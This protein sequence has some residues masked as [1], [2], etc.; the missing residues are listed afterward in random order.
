M[1]HM[2]SLREVTGPQIHLA[3]VVD[4]ERGAGPMSQYVCG[5]CLGCNVICG[6]PGGSWSAVTKD[7]VLPSY[8]SLCQGSDMT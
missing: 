2:L 1:H 6:R 8:P 7:P 4:P 3:G 5:H